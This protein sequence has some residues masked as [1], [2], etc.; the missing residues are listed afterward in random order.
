MG[1]AVVREMCAR[2]VVGGHI[3]KRMTA[4]L[5]YNAMVKGYNLRQ[6]P[7]GRVFHG[8]RVAH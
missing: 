7:K 4:E 8:D 2:R 6:A 3:D 5:V 1:V